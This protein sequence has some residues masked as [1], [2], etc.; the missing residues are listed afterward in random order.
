MKNPRIATCH[1]LA[2]AKT[3]TAN[4]AEASSAHRL[5]LAQTLQQEAA[6]D[7][8][9]ARNEGT[10]RARMAT[11]RPGDIRAQHIAREGEDLRDVS[12]LYYGTPSHWRALMLYNGLPSSDLEVGQDVL[13]PRQTGSDG[14]EG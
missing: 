9:K 12:A 14:G 4:P 10:L 6:R 2:G 13:I 7:A 11:A 1:T 3:T 5:L 8:K